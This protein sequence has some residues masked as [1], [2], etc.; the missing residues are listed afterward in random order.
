M[1]NGRNQGGDRWHDADD[2]APTYSIDR[3]TVLQTT[4][5]GLAGLAAFSETTT[6]Q[7]T[8]GGDLIWKF[9]TEGEVYSS[10]TVVDGTVFI[11]SDDYPNGDVYALDADD[12]SEQW[13][14]ETGT[15][16]GSSLTVVDGTVFIGSYDFPNG[17]VYA[18]D[19]DDGS[20][21]WRFE[22]GA[23]EGSSPTVVDGTVFIGS[24]DYN[25]Y[26]LDA[27]DGSEQ[28]R[29]E[30]GNPANS[31][32]TVVD[33]TVF[34]GSEDE[35]VYALDADDGSEQWRFETG[36]N[37]GSSPTVVDG[38]VFI[39]SNDGNVYALDAD[40]GS[41]QWRFETGGDVDSSP[42]VVDGTVFIGSNDGNVYALDADDGS[43]QWRFEAGEYVGSSPTVVDGTVFIGSSDRNVYA[44]DAGVEGSSEGSRVNLGTLGHHN[45][46][47]NNGPTPP[48]T[49]DESVPAPKVTGVVT[50]SAGNPLTNIEVR[51][52][53]QETDAGVGG[54]ISTTGAEG[55]YAIS[56]KPDTEY[57]VVV[58]DQ[59]G[60]EQTEFEEFVT[61]A[62]DETLQVDITLLSKFEVFEQQKL[63]KDDGEGIQGLAP[64]IDEL[65]TPIIT[66]EETVEQEI[67]AIKSGVAAGNIEQDLADDALERMVFGEALVN[68]SLEVY[69]GATPLN[70]EGYEWS[71]GEVMF[72]DDLPAYDLPFQTAKSIVI[73]MIE[74]SYTLKQIARSAVGEFGDQ[75]VNRILNAIE[76]YLR[77]VVGEYVLSDREKQK[78]S[79]TLEDIEEAV[80]IAEMLVEIKGAADE[81][82]RRLEQGPTYDNI[83][84]VIEDL[85]DPLAGLLAQSFV[86]RAELSIKLLQL[87]SLN[88][89]L[90]AESLSSGPVFKNDI[91]TIADST[92]TTLN[93]VEADVK[94]V[95]ETMNPESEALKE[96]TT[97]AGEL[98]DAGS[99][100]VI[101]I[102]KSIWT[103][104]RDLVSVIDAGFE[105]GFALVRL[106]E[107]YLNI[108]TAVNDITALENPR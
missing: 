13:R 41:E 96:V 10:P 71:Q 25:V 62:E 9:E 68:R 92:Q 84:G 20:E 16:V 56:V 7:S 85:A 104:V 33:G 82:D 19:A 11:G 87:D 102:L 78:N 27:D 17:D 105:F 50:D 61:V 40:D 83:R 49:P 46:F 73:G 4:G 53:N 6:A 65:S 5:T 36:G 51:A 1:P 64:R 32:P 24:N 101:Q 14:F 35:N 18:L 34:I 39:G 31:S 77:D 54:G 55:E 76:R 70:L 26:A 88:T 3:R 45:V 42:T 89:T 15:Y 90:S 12:G 29:F 93:R 38:T 75:I 30:T 91:V 23:Y 63:G 57:R 58:V 66:E 81:A 108:G 48:G 21:Q 22:T 8:S 79:E 67:S 69:T 86:V 94:S 103:I 98:A 28:W 59:F 60:L 47:A 99:V 97:L 43:E 100:D 106:S 95:K 52:Q 37:V 107:I 80:S 44:L 74:A 72:N 2:E